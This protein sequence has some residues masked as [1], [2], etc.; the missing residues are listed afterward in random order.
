M[1]VRVAPSYV[2]VVEHGSQLQ[3]YDIATLAKLKRPPLADVPSPSHPTHSVLVLFFV[4]A[5][6][7]IHAHKAIGTKPRVLS[8]GY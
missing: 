3:L 7:R 4:I 5:R 6:R 8:Q 2:A 1:D